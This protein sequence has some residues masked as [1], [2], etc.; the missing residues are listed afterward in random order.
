M[1]VAELHLPGIS[2]TGQTCV[3]CGRNFPPSELIQIRNASVCAAC[4][5]VFLQR[6]SE[7]A[8][9]PSATTGLWRSGNKIVT[10][11]ETIFPERCIKC[12]QPTNG[13]LKK[14]VLYWQHPSPHYL[15]HPVQPLL[16]AFSWSP[17]IAHRALVGK[18]AMVHDR[19]C[20]RK[21]IAPPENRIS[22]SRPGA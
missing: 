12:N 20:V 6:L 1:A 2:A 3:E 21:R 5:P 11:T 9:L 4:K 22:L 15:F 7:G 10:V 18:K 13:Y 17:R 16:C 14:R 8:A 19:L